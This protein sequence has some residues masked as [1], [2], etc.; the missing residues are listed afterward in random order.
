MERT[1]RLE[2]ERDGAGGFVAKGKYVR[3]FRLLL[4]ASMFE[5]GKDV[6]IVFNGTEYRR[7]PRPS[8][9][10]LLT[11]FVERFDRTFLPVAELRI[12]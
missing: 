5:T 9:T 3:K 4:D 7:K 2:V 8:A 1:A 10:V 12:P 11:E 6:R